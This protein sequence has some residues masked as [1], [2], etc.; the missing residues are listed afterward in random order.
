[1]QQQDTD[2]G[3]SEMRTHKPADQLLRI[4]VG[5]L[6]ILASFAWSGYFVNSACLS[7]AYVSVRIPT[8]HA[9]KLRSAVGRMPVGKDTVVGQLKGPLDPR[10][11]VRS[12]RMDD[13]IER[14]LINRRRGVGRI[15]LSVWGPLG[16]ST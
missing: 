1:M 15:T 9:T 8:H 12:K 2:L 11:P 3:K 5:S 7:H 6:R 16:P 13:E 10:Y 14:M 4:L